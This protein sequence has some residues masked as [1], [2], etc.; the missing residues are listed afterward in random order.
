[1]KLNKKLAYAAQKKGI[2]ED[3]FNDLLQTEDKARLIQMYLSGIDFCLS[4]EYPSL[5]FIRENFVG[6]MEG[7]GVF[8]DETIKTENYRHV[9][10]LGR[11]EGLAE[12]TGFEVGQVFAKHESKL[13]VK[14]SGN[15]FV[16]VDV[17]D[18][19]TVEII[20]SDNAKICVNHYGGNLTTTTDAEA[21]N[22]II[23]I[24]RKHTKTY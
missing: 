6:V 13:T 20:A 11:C 21:G 2:C 10:A 8:L 9:V 17:F 3:W 1:M 22:A 4:K 19:T 15:A 18:S 24:I 16:M 14:A 7:Y 12:Y 5:D 23:K